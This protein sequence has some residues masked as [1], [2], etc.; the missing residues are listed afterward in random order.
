L[1]VYYSG[2]VA[3]ATMALGYPYKAE[4]GDIV[5]VV[6]Q[7]RC[8]YVIGVLKAL[9]KTSFFVPGDFEI[10][11][12]RG[13]ISLV[14]GKGIEI[15]GPDFKITASKIELVAQTLIERLREATCWVKETWQ[16]RAGRVR[17]Q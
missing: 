6:G 7:H 9:G 8:L 4:I 13:R 16:I 5:L 15:K 3:L 12:P 17:A 10:C 2:E 1:E 14:G 11:A